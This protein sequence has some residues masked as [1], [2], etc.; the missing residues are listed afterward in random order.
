MRA[1]GAADAPCGRGMSAVP[2]ETPDNQP[3]THDII[4]MGAS[5]GG[6]EALTAFVS[7]LPQNF[8][9]AI[10][11][12]LHMPARGLSFLDRILS[13][14]GPLHAHIAQDGEPIIQGRIYV[15]RADCHLLLTPLCA[16][17]THGPREN[18][19]RPA[20]DPLFRTAAVAFGPRVVGIVFSGMLNDGTAGLLAIKERGGVA[21]AQDPE[22]A[23]FPQMPKSANA[24]VDLDG[25]DTPTGLAHKVIQLAREVVGAPEGAFPVSDDMAFEA[26]AVGLDPSVLDR[27]ERPGMLT[28]FSCPE[29]QGPIWETRSGQLPR[30]RCRVGHA[31]TAETMVEGQ[32]ENVEN[33]MWVAVNTLEESAQLYDHLA[34]SARAR[35]QGPKADAFERQARSLRLRATTIRQMAMS[36]EALDA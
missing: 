27:D 24:Y 5:A 21:L 9:G 22:T 26:N 6:V 20:I 8:P 1:T 17:V 16:R 25:M 3:H 7:G 33:S 15:A 31:F 12:V 2:H 13:H 28:A 4:V 35:R 18:R 11:V 29:C 34:V 23:L 30:F 32:A 14:A 10:F 36:G 19:S